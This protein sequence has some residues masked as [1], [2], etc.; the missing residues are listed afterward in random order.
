M[1]G[2]MLALDVAVL[3]PVLD[4][5][6]SMLAPADGRSA[7]SQVLSAQVGVVLAGLQD[8]PDLPPDRT[9]DA[10]AQL[11][12]GL[13]VAEDD[14]GVIWAWRV[15]PALEASLAVTWSADRGTDLTVEIDTRTWLFQQP[16]GEQPRQLFGAEPVAQILGDSSN[17]VAAEQV[18]DGVTAWTRDAYQQWLN[19]QAPSPSWVCPACGM[20]NDER[21]PVC[22]T[23]GAPVPADGS[24]FVPGAILDPPTMLRGPMT[25]AEEV[26]AAIQELFEP[27]AREA[28]P[29]DYLQRWLD[30]V[31]A[32]AWGEAVEF[33]SRAAD[34]AVTSANCV[35][36]GRGIPR[37]AD[38]CPVCGAAQRP[39]G[40]PPRPSVLPR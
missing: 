27:S 23:C 8:C 31:S 38:L 2:E 22:A 25:G 26:P 21:G 36:C 1:D 9:S 12:Q 32:K 30:E 20:V 3:A 33:V 18:K 19:K 37:A 17:A 4:L 7:G 11:W 24:P 5:L 28:Q 34:H 35:A 14:R 13:R 29:S 16:P 39:S 40:T 6:V 10:D 15:G